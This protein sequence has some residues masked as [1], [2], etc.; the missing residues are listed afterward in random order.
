[1]NLLF[2]FQIST[3][4]D[5]LFLLRKV[6]DESVMKTISNK[7][8]PEINKLRNR[9]TLLEEEVKRFK[10]ILL[11]ALNQIELRND[12]WIARKT[13]TATKSTVEFIRNLFCIPRIIRNT[14]EIDGL[15]YQ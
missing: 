1:M 8:G 6:I 2:Y 9:L 7:T 10:K 11:E 5:E 12:C 4:E 3:T 15:N 13:N 14:G